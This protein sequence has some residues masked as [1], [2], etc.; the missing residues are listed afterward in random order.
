MTLKD[1]FRFLIG[2]F[3]VADRS[4]LRW[5]L[6]GALV[7]LLLAKSSNL[8]TP[9]LLGQTV[10]TLDRNEVMDGWLLG[11]LGL[12]FAYAFSRLAALVF[13][14]GREVLFTSV[15]QHAIRTLTGHAFTHLHRLPLPFHLSR[16]TGSLDRLIERGTKAVDFLLRYVAFNVGPTLIELVIVSGI[17]W[18][19]FGGSYALVIGLSMLAYII[20]TLQV[21][22]WRLRFRRTM[23]AADNKVA[24]RLVDSFINIE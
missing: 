17:V 4:D 20:L 19:L 6:I 24:G 9:W 15:S 16:Q 8:A 11:A 2:Y 18:L 10:D 3:W 21:T 12:V 5:R 22:T 23:N 13:S 1:Q 7:C 14:E